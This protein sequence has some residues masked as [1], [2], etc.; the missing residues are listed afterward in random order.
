MIHC[1]LPTMALMRPM[2]HHRLLPLRFQQMFTRLISL[3]L[4]DIPQLSTQ[5]S[6]MR[7]ALPQKVA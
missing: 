3:A 2:A 4:D 7:I 6:P 1:L 5:E